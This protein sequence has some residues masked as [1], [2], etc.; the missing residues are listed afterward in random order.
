MY[1]KTNK[2]H[3]N[4]QKGTHVLVRKN[5]QLHTH[6]Y[7]VHLLIFLI[8]FF[9]KS[10]LFH[11]TASR[12]HQGTSKH[13]STADNWH[14]WYYWHICTEFSEPHDTRSQFQFTFLT[15]TLAHYLRCSY[16]RRVV[17]LLC[18]FVFLL[19]LLHIHVSC[20]MHFRAYQSQR[21][22][23]LAFWGNNVCTYEL[24]Q[25]IP[26]SATRVQALSWCSWFFRFL[27]LCAFLLLLRSAHCLCA[28]ERAA[29]ER[30]IIFLISPFKRVCARARA[31]CLRHVREWKFE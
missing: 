6:I 31:L 8:Y 30:F 29:K 1:T 11:T 9:Y 16:R 14:Y 2:V 17:P 3:K 7:R 23:D 25:L 24:F 19:L 15:E 4:T 26:P 18:L 22:R 13:V 5:K 20:V 12:R 27:F 28:R 10:L 21:F